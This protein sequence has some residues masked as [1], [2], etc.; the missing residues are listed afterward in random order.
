MT[1]VFAAFAFLIGT[2]L[3]TTACESTQDKSKR[4]AGSSAVLSDEGLVVRRQN[5]DVKVL[6]TKA[7]QDENGGAVVVEMRNVSKQALTNVPVSIDV[8]GAGGKSVFRNDQA[9]LETALTHAPLLT[10]NDK[11]LWVNDQVEADAK[12]KSVTARVGM[13]KPAPT[14]QIPTIVLSRPKLEIDPVSGTAAVG[15]ATNRSKIE[16][17]DL[18]IFAV[19]KKGGKI[20]AAGRGQIRRIKPDK[21]ARF[22][23]FFIGNP[24]GA[25]LELAAPPTT[26]G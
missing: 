20:V 3:V 19:G 8:R 13:A 15:F 26:L 17:R 6:E 14:G 11:F 4:L 7:L 9:G 1:R 24:R 16:Q 2:A 22:Q 23:I 25:S 12:P 18:V 10:P 5:P 21:R